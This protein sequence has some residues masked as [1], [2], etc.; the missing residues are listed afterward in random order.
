L[1]NQPFLEPLILTILIKYVNRLLT[2][3]CEVLNFYLVGYCG[4]LTVKNWNKRAKVSANTTPRDIKDLVEKDIL[5]PQQGRVWDV[6]YGIR[7]SDSILVIPMPEESQQ[8]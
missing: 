7:Y 1:Q 2:W 3:Q 6:F 4:K 8:V 5:I